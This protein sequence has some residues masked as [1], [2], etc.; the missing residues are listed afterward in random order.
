[1]KSKLKLLLHFFGCGGFVMCERS[2]ICH[3]INVLFILMMQ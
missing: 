3:D 1:M 2:W